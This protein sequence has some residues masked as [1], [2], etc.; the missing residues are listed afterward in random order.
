M[1]GAETGPAG[2]IFTI[3]YEGASLD[4]VLRTLAARGVAVVLDVRE[5]PLSRRAGFSK[6]PLSA[7]LE[8]AG[9]GY[10]HLKGLGTPKEGRTAARQ[11]DLERFWSVVEETMRTPEA[12]HD[13]H[14]AA[15]AAGRQPACLLCF[16]ASP[17]LC[18]RRRV[19]DALH[20]RFG[21][22][23]EHLAPAEPSF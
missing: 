15:A 7:A 5:L 20:D 11:G 18:H 2:T 1:N 17:H 12:E 13:L 4:S 22:T 3:G 14:R 16:E 6:R 19:A 8:E 21:F 10:A 23:V 9:I